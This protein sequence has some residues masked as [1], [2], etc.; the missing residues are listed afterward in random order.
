MWIESLYLCQN[1]DCIKW[2]PLKEGH[3]ALEAKGWIHAFNASIS[4][5]SLFERLLNWEGKI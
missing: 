3:I 4:L 5:G 1:M 2:R